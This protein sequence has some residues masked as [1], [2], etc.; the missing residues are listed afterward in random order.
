MK[1][2]IKNLLSSSPINFILNV[3]FYWELIKQL[4]MRD[5]VGKYKGSFFGF[6]WALVTPIIMLGVYTFVFSV[7]FGMR[8]GDDSIG[9]DRVLFSLLLF[10]GIIV[11]NFFCEILNKSPT[12]ITLNINYVKKVIFPLHLMPLALLI[13]SF[14]Q[15][16]ISFF[17]LIIALFVFDIP[18]GINILLFPII[19]FPLVIFAFGISMILTSVG[20]FLRDISH[21]MNILSTVLIFLSPIFYP[22]SAVPER[23]HIFILANPLTIIIEQLRQV[24]IFNNNPQWSL[25]IGYYVF[26]IIVAWFGLF[27]FQKTRKGFADVL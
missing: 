11:L 25:I 19:F 23:F 7:I 9:E 15:S 24:I 13:S 22:I 10:I 5:L 17:I 18:V 8:W 12:L 2:N 6:Y 4:V 26:S 3:F 27:W 20:V 16:L 14:L 21:T 1:N